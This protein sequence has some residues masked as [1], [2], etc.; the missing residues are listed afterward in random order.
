MEIYKNDM[1]NKNILITGASSGIGKA[2]AFYL[3]EQGANVIL[4]AR[5]EKELKEIASK[6]GESAK[7]Y[8][9]DLENRD[10]ISGIFE[11]CRNQN[12]LLNGFVHSAGIA[13]PVPV[14]IAGYESTEKMI[15]VNTLSFMELSKYFYQKKYSEAGSSI[16]AI[17]SMAA[18][19]PFAG[20]ASYAASKAAL[21]AMVKV[22]AQ[23]FLKRKIRV[24]AIMPSYVDTPM[25]E[26]GV[27]YGMNHDIEQMPL[28]VI[29]P[30]QIAY[31]TEFLL[32]DKAVHITGAEI[33]VTSGVC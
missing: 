23:E 24:N 10:E 29:D 26:D 7:Y 25:V 16:V 27:A 4:V 2:T 22:M 13:A 28:G 19:R 9:C 11:F 32:S 30:K 31:L 17:S 6:L 1:K 5:R 33:P 14:R 8:V 18:V 15:K 12:I 21:N 3:A 20:Q